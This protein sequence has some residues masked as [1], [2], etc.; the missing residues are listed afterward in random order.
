MNLIV[1]VSAN[2]GI[3][4]DGDLLFRISPDL[5]RFKRLTLGKTVVMGHRTFKSLP[6]GLPLKRRTN[7]I[8]TR[9]VGLAIPGAQVCHSVEGVLITLKAY[10][11]Q[12]VFII[13]GEAIYRSF[14]DV[15][16]TAYVT[17]VDTMPPADVFM[18]NLDDLP[19]W[20]LAEES[21]PMVCNGLTYRYCEYR[22]DE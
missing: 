11:S 17:K 4:K 18:P 9:Q 20:I 7:I 6:G 8:L 12:D 16:T 14:V 15:C 2:W 22:R 3:G 19:E 5:Q 10:S 21:N 13:G 1:A